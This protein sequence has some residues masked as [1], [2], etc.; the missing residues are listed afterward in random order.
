MSLRSRRGTALFAVLLLVG[1]MGTPV[2]AS[3]GPEVRGGWWAMM[4]DWLDQA[5]GA[6]G[7]QPVFEGSACGVDPNGR[8]IICPESQTFDGDSACGVDPDGRPRPCPSV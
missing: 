6:V 8:P 7:L 1:A 4:G 2:F 3:E 5:L